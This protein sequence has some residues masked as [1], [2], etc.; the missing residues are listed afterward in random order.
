MMTAEE[1]KGF[2]RRQIDE[3]WNRG[4]LD[5]AEECFTQDF[6]SHD[7]SSPEEIRGPE[8]FK[9][10]VAA[11]RAAFPDFRMEIVDQ[12]AEAEKVVTRYV[13]TCTHK[14][15]LAGI[16][17]TGNRVEVAGMGIDYFRGGKICESW[18]YY[19]VMGLMQQMGVATIP[20]PRLMVHVLVDQAKKS[21]S[22]ASARRR[23][24]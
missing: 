19:D 22:R 15:E 21:L 20:G 17:P 5:A 16:P 2:V 7:P 6:V 10:N 13:T 9:Q 11:I 12:V 3:L 4:N 14:G 24:K 8:G 1:R 18:E 23:R